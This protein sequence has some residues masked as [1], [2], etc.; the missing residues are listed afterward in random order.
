MRVSRNHTSIDN[1]SYSLNATPL[2]YVRSYKYL[3]VHITNSLSWSDHINHVTSK[4]NRML[5]YLK[6]NFPVAPTFLK[7]QL[8][9]TY[10]RPLL[11][12]AACVWDP[13]HVTLVNKLEAIQNRS[14]RFILRSYNRTSS[15][16]AMKIRLNLPP[17]VMRRKIARLCAFQ[18][19]YY[20]NHVLKSRLLQPASFISSRIDHPHKVHIPRSNTVTFS[21][22]FLPNTCRDW[23][24]LSA[25]T[26]SITEPDAFRQAL[27]SSM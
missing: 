24:L 14:S 21:Q 26:A 3:G 25:S 1:Y 9:I 11:E 18:K 23:N 19:I 6:R 7:K 4:S 13:G 15:V 22:S 12:Y 2:E 16:S 27:T 20:H 8:Y 17:L 10:I 5:G